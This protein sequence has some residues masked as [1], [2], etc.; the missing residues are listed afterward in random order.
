MS[1]SGESAEPC[2][3]P[4]WPERFG[5]ATVQ[6]KSNSGLECFGHICKFNKKTACQ[7]KCLRAAVSK[8]YHA[9]IWTLVGP[10]SMLSVCGDSNE[11]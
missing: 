3:I 10:W 5:Q 2:Y 11:P 9:C 8:V 1:A 6:K 7:C 4:C